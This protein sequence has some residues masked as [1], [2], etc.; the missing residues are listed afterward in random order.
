MDALGVPLEEDTAS[1][2]T[3]VITPSDGRPAGT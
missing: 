3:G 2:V 1:E